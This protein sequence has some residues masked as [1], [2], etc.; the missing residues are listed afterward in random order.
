MPEPAVTRGRS[1]DLVVVANRLPVA[2]VDGA[3]QRSPGGLVGAVLPALP[4]DLR[5]A[6]VG[7]TGCPD[8]GPLDAGPLDTGPL[9]TGPLDAGPL[10]NTDGASLVGGLAL[11]PVHLSRAEIDGFYLGLSNEALWPLYHDAIHPS[12]FCSDWWETYRAVNERYA[13]RAAALV[14]PGGAVWVHDYH[15]QLVPRML[16]AMRP[17]VRIA[18]F[19]HVPFPPPELFARLP[20][21]RQI[22]DGLCGA[23][24]LAFQT[25]SDVENFRQAVHGPGRPGVGDGLRVGSRVVRVRAVPASVDGRGIDRAARDPGVVAAAHRIRQSLGRPRTVILGVDRLD[26]TK[27]IDVRLVALRRLLAEGAL[28]AGSVTLVQVAVPSRQGIRGYAAHREQV[29]R[30]VGEIN[31]DHGRLGAPAVHYMFRSLPFD[32]LVALYR[33]ADV[34]LVTPRRDGMN[35]VAKEYVASRVDDT[36]RV[37]L[38]EFAGAADELGDA[39]LVNPYDE[40]GLAA[41]LRRAVELPAADARRRMQAMRAHVLHHDAQAWARA[42]LADLV[43]H[44]PDRVPHGRVAP[45]PAA[46]RPPSSRPAAA[47]R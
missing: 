2:H 36:G 13:R 1:I 11:A 3:W 23:D 14:A 26:Y 6:W 34:M 15:L 45:G 30:L 31:G 24:A 10:G 27:G 41:G 19:L 12:A 8:G 35:L 9:D 25:R 38:S 39:L 32:E 22:L 4:R 44:D 7:W 28:E 42:C 18:F 17:D 47:Y 16:R 20:W 5:T 37:V 29:E 43:R 33:A 21:R 46:V 40:E